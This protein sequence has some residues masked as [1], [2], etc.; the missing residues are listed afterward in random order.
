LRRA[1]DYSGGLVG[2][3]ENDEGKIFVEPQGICVM[4]GV[5]LDDRKAE[6]ALASVA[7]HMATPDGILLVQPAYSS[8]HPELG[9]IS[10]YPPGYKENASVF[11]HT[12][13]WIMIAETRTGNADRAFDYYLRIKPVGA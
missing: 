7:Q 6:R 11:C 12:N 10:S 9:E 3:N 2:S 5:G 8:Y 1:Y 13:P 4:A